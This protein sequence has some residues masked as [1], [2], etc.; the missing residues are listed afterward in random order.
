MK[1]KVIEILVDDFECVWC[2]HGEYSVSNPYNSKKRKIYCDR[3]GRENHV[4]YKV[5]N[6][7]IWDED[8]LD[9][10]ETLVAVGLLVCVLVFLFVMFV[11]FCLF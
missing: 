6:P 11:L 4:D 10:D 2:G 8:R 7:G 9:S 5:V 1:R 3:C